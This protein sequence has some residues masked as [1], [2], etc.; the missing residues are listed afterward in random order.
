[1]TFWN[2]NLVLWLY[3]W[4]SEW[5]GLLSRSDKITTKNRKSNG[6][7][8]IY[9][10]YAS[11]IWRHDDVNVRIRVKNNKQCVNRNRSFYSFF[12]HHFFLFFIAKGSIWDF[13]FLPDIRGRISFYQFQDSIYIYWKLLKWWWLFIL[14]LMRSRNRYSESIQMDFRKK[15]LIGKSKTEWTSPL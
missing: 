12:P 6:K 2:N 3:W 1:M 4:T 10:C 8:V 5:L 11:L 15:H 14:S 13:S 7:L 9:H